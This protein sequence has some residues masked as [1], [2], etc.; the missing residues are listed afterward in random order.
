MANEFVIK[1]GFQS[2]GDSDITGSLTVQNGIT[3]SLFGTASWAISASNVNIVAGPNITINRGP[4]DSYEITGSA[5]G[6]SAG[7]ESVYQNLTS[8]ILA[9]TTY[10]MPSGLTYASSSTYE[11]LEVYVNGIRLRYNADY[12]P[13]PT[14]SLQFNITV[15]SGSELTYTTLK[16]P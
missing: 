7:V 11:Y 9:G 3:G 8:S 16:R 12:I 5:G 13:L 6:G 4:N 14:A 1:N 2:R 10:V 15:P